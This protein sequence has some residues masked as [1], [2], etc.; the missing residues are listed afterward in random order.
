MKNILIA[1]DYNPSSE[2]VAEAGYA[3][4]KVMNAMV[5]LLHVMTE[6]AYYAMNYSPIMGYQGAYTDG[7]IGIVDDLKKEAKDFLTAASRHLGDI[8]IKIKVL[9]G[10]IEEAILKYAKS[11]KADLIVLGSH[12]HK[13]LG[14]LLTPDM[15]V[16]VIR[17]SK[18]PSLIIPTNEE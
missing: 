1:L 13:G 16:H 17:H 18:I 9:E 14:R 5:T 6:P 2:K 8:N 15:A 3:L 7:T 4:A 11:C 12:S 10:D